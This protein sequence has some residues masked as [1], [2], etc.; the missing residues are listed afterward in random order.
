MNDLFFSIKDADSEA[1]SV[2]HMVIGG[3]YRVAAA[4]APDFVGCIACRVDNERLCF[5]LHTGEG[6][7]FVNAAI[8]HCEEMTF[9]RAKNYVFSDTR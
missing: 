5:W 8:E 2:R 4:R 1:T 7:Q 3:L 6:S 9:V